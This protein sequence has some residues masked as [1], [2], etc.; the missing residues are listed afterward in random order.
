MNLK[1]FIQ[2]GILLS[3]LCIGM[4]PIADDGPVYAPK[5]V[6]GVTDRLEGTGSRTL[7]GE[8]P[9]LTVIAPSRAG[10]TS[11]AQP[12]LYWYVSQD[13]ESPVDVSI[14]EMPDSSGKVLLEIKLEGVEAGFNRLDLRTKGVNLKLDVKYDWNITFTWPPQA[15]QEAA[16]F[17]PI[18]V[19]SRATLI[20][21]EASPELRQQVVEAKP[22]SL[23]GLYAQAGFWYD[24][25][26]TLG[27]LI[28]QNP[29]SRLYPNWRAS[30]L[31][32]ESLDTIT[33]P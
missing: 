12:V 17:E 10:W 20:R 32:Q 18:P 29:D 5:D 8:P 33:T 23:P 9:K 4:L 15:M 19:M 7:F 28:E 6:D 1:Y 22:E 21:K 2:A 3:A 31:K 11:N 24:S 13:I 14:T 27:T 25:L 16:G 30:L 26:A